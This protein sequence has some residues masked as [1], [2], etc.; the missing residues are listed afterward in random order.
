MLLDLPLPSPEA[1]ITTP[2]LK[3]ERDL[4]D[5]CVERRESLV[6]PRVTR[7]GIT[8]RRM[9]VCLDRGSRVNSRWPE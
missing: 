8:P 4:R 5:R 1:L 9:P 7:N 2:V 6:P 3:R